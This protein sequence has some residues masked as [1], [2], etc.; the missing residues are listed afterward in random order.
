MSKKSRTQDVINIICDYFGIDIRQFNSK[1]RKSE[2]VLARHLAI[3]FLR[4]EIGMTFR[5]IS[6]V[7]NKEVSTV[8]RNFQKICDLMEHDI[9]IQKDARRLKNKFNKNI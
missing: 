9:V 2:I 8:V 6:E 5:E 3:Y 4:Y 7:I 1:S